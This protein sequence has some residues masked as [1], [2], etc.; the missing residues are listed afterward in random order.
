MSLEG[1]VCKQAGLPVS[2]CGLGCRRAG[3]IALPSF[4]ASMSSVDELVKLFFLE[5]T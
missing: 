3:D 2:F 4:I 1:D 5:L